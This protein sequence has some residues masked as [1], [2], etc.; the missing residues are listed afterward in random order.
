M[1]H[2]ETMASSAKHQITCIVRVA[3]GPTNHSRRTCK[4][5]LVDAQRY[6]AWHHVFTDIDDVVHIDW[7][8]GENWSR[9]LKE[10]YNEG[11]AIATGNSFTWKQLY[12]MMTIRREIIDW[13]PTYAIWEAPYCC[14][15][16]FCSSRSYKATQF[17]FRLL[18]KINLNLDKTPKRTRIQRWGE[19]MQ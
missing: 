5:H 14:C 12:R 3:A 8:N 19:M 15:R 16:W 10:C 6:W 2:R 7:E 11:L 4:Q 17:H 13:R 9:L 18:Y 1:T